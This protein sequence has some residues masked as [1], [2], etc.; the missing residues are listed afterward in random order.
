MD[1]LTEKI[2]TEKKFWEQPKSEPINIKSGSS[3]LTR[4]DFE[5]QPYTYNS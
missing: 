1:T 2:K 3:Y 4:E 5:Y